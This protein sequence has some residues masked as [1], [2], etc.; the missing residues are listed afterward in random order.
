MKNKNPLF[1]IAALSTCCMFF[2]CIYS[3]K[4]TAGPE[5]EL[6][7]LQKWTFSGTEFTY[8]SGIAVRSLDFEDQPT[9]G[10]TVWLTDQEIDCSSRAETQLPSPGGWI[11]IK[12]PEISLGKGSVRLTV[13]H[14]P[15][16]GGLNGNIDVQGVAT[17]THADTTAKKTVS[18]ALEHHEDSFDPE[19]G[20]GSAD[21]KGSFT[22]P[23]CPESP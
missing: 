17:L 20:F 4:E 23:Y 1:R 12:Y 13:G 16:G 18:G 7:P 5:A 8:R 22:V 2:T 10:I 21:I 15:R 19:D 6:P 9:T 14:W 3:C 11:G